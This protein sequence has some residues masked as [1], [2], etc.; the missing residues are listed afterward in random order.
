MGLNGVFVCVCMFMCRM[1]SEE[2]SGFMTIKY[3]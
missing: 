3:E 1:E 2:L